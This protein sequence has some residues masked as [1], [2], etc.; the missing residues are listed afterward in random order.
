[1]ISPSYVFSLLL[2]SGHNSSAVPFLVFHELPSKKNDTIPSSSSSSLFPSTTVDLTFCVAPSYDSL[3]PKLVTEWL[4]YHLGLVEGKGHF[5]WYKS[6]A[7]RSYVGLQEGL[8]PFVEAGVMEIENVERGKKYMSSQHR[9][10]LSYT[11]CLHRSRYFS[12]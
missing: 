12:K 6:N 5:F 1:M 4:S 11:D 2:S 3:N 9:Q 8:A 10:L 7:I